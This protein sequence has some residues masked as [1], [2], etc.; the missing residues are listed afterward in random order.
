MTP[1]A[2]LIH[3]TGEQT[4]EDI[5]ERIDDAGIFLLAI[6]RDEVSQ[7]L[8]EGLRQTLLNMQKDAETAA[9][10]RRKLELVFT[11][12]DDDPRE[13]WDIPEVRDYVARLDAFFPHW[14]YFCCLEGQTLRVLLYCL[15]SLE[16]V[17]GHP[18]GRRVSGRDEIEFF[19]RHYLALNELFHRFGLPGE[20]N[21]RVSR[22]IAEYF[23]LDV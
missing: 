17:G 4:W 22:E 8:S 19:S 23:G 11:G 2:N 20:E 13:L 18:E 21:A 14:F 7:S 10:F 15:S 12:Y 5:V 6:D 16:P 9:R 1:E 3:W